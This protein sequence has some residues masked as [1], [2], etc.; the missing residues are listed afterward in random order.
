M[1]CGK[2]DDRTPFAILKY[3][4]KTQTSAAEMMRTMTRTAPMDRL[5]RGQSLDFGYL[6]AGSGG[7]RPI[8]PTV[9]EPGAGL[10]R[11]DRPVGSRRWCQSRR[12][13][14]VRVGSG[15][16]SGAISGQVPRSATQ[17]VRNGVGAPFTAQAQKFIRFESATQPV[18]NG[19]GAPDGAAAGAGQLVPDCQRHVPGRPAPRPPPPTKVRGGWSDLPARPQARYPASTGQPTVHATQGGMVAAL[20]GC[21]TCAFQAE[22]ARELLVQDL[23]VPALPRP[24]QQLR[25]DQRPLPTAAP[26]RL[27]IDQP[28]GGARWTRRPW[29]RLWMPATTSR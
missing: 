4:Y 1:A 10:A 14:L 29:R 8:R 12:L 16:A 13:W 19:V 27:G 23:H 22:A 21:Q 25:S 18:R 2:A 3:S 20:T 7:G 11:V 26:I 15:Q 24:R 9:D 28:E 5:H 17:P 6:E